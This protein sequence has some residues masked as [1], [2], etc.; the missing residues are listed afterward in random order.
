MGAEESERDAEHRE[1]GER[2]AP[3]GRIVYKA[4]LKEG[5]EKLARPSTALFWSDLA[6]GL[7][8]TLALGLIIKL[9]IDYV[10]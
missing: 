9:D 8:T 3:S 7:S 2:S 4:I 10:R 1:A 6:T 5:E